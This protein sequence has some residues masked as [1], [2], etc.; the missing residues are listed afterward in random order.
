MGLSKSMEFLRNVFLEDFE[1]ESHARVVHAEGSEKG[2]DH[3]RIYTQTAEQKENGTAIL[4][5]IYSEEVEMPA[6]NTDFNLTRN[7]NSSQ[8]KS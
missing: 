1:S 6:P 4:H 5:R 8:V 3:F 2:F 7:S